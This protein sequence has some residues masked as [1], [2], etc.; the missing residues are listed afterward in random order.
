M[1]KEVLRHRHLLSDVH[2]FVMDSFAY[3]LSLPDHKVITDINRKNPRRLGGFS[4]PNPV[5]MRGLYY[6]KSDATFALIPDIINCPNEIV[7]NT[8][9]VYQQVFWEEP[10][11][12][13]RT[14]QQDRQPLIYDNG[15]SRPGDMFTVGNTSVT[16]TFKDEFSNTAICSFNVV[17]LPAKI[18]QPISAASSSK[19]QGVA[20]DFLTTEYI[21]DHT[22]MYSKIVNNNYT[23]TMDTLDVAS[24]LPV[25]YLA[26]LFDQ[27]ADFSITTFDAPDY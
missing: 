12:M 22:L 21:L 5:A 10:Y 7:M 23:C 3:Y 6:Y 1:K 20:L 2:S 17:L 14:S 9:Q 26:H 16:Y 4:T 25:R 15:T 19:S 24:L 8:S 11:A 13:S 27:F 18:T